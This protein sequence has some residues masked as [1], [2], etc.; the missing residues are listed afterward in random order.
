MWR[1]LVTAKRAIFLQNIP[2]KATI[3]ERKK[4]VILGFS[5]SLSLE[6]KFSQIRSKFH[7]FYFGW[8]LTSFYKFYKAFSDADRPAAYLNPLVH[9]ALILLLA[10][11]EITWDMSKFKCASTS[12]ISHFREKCKNSWKWSNFQNLPQSKMVSTPHFKRSI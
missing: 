9:G 8:F 4:E 10:C 7:F 6:G 12:S 2:I 3:A 11:T 1:S 5:F